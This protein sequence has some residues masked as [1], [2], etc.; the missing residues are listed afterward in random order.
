VIQ[1]V[2]LEEKLNNLAETILSYIGS[3]IEE[4]IQI[5]KLYYDE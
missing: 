2:K 1:N 3:A 5:I 4:P